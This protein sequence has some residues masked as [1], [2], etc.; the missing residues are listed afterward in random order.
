M[1]A[2]ADVASIDE[3]EAHAQAALEWQTLLD[4]IAEGTRSEPGRFR[5]KSLQPSASAAEA[6]SRMARVR[7]LLELGEHGVELP[8]SEFPDIL[9]TLS[10]ASVG[11]SASGS[12]FLDVLRV[13][14]QAAAL[15]GVAK[16]HAEQAPELAAV[17]DSDAKLT[18]VAERLA[19]CIERDG[20]VSD[21]ATPA[22]AEA[23]QRAREVR[24]ELKRRLGDLTQRYADVLSGTYYTERDGRYVL[25]VR[26]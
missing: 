2:P 1:Q 12:D 8:L 3:L 22:L 26:S 5:V 25:P 15:R 13:L 14:E 4:R 18:R 24:E 9:E 11:A 10:R 16:E 17:L 19:S 6:R 23:R 20:N 21:G 7:A